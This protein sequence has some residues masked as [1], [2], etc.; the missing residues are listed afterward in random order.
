MS[1]LT[2]TQGIL[3]GYLFFTFGVVYLYLHAPYFHSFVDTWNEYL[4]SALMFPKFPL[5]PNFSFLD[6][7]GTVFVCKRYRESSKGDK[8]W[9]EILLACVLMQFGGTLII[10]LVLGQVPSWILSRAALPGFFLA[11]WLTFYSP[12]DIFYNTVSKNN[13]L[14]F[15]LGVFNAVSAGHAVTSWGLDKAYNN[16][17]HTNAES[18]GKSYFL[19]ILCGTIAA[20]GGGILAEVFNFFS[21]SKSFTLRHK[22]A[23]FEIGNYSVSAGLNRSF[24][25]AMI[26]YVLISDPK[27][28]LPISCSIDKVTGHSII[29]LLQ[30]S[31][32]FMMYHIP[33]TDIYQEFSNFVLDF[34]NIPSFYSFEA[35][36][37]EKSE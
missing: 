35:V 9:F 31:A 3:T 27:E 28:F 5:L 4:E 2:K 8:S 30:I 13:F 17:Y 12:D 15:F 34:L 16:A 36:D 23:F 18:F 21:N 6:F 32:Y 29:A 33:Q 19:C 24:W 11:W 7:V 26:Y 25:L 37:H 20:C 22:S 10:A 14:L 1:G